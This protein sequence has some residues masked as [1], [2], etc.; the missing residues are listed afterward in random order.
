M[1]VGEPGTLL[2]GVVAL[3]VMKNRINNESGGSGH[4]FQFEGGMSTFLIDNGSTVFADRFQGTTGWNPIS[5]QM[6]M[7]VLGI[8]VVKRWRE[9]F[10]KFLRH[11]LN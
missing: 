6:V 11:E 1:G 3:G 8:N 2:L 5:S 10:S 7:D 9:K 4:E